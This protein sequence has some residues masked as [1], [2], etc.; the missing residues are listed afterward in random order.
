MRR[1]LRFREG[2]P[3][4]MTQLLRTQFALD[5]SLYFST[6]EVEPDDRDAATL[7][8]PVRITATKS[9]H[10]FTLGA[11]YG[12]DTSVRGTIG[13]TNTRVN[14]RGHRLRFELKASTVTQRIDARY[15]IPIGDPALEQF[16][17][18]LT[19]R[20]TIRATSIPPRPRS[21]PR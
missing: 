16:S 11:G 7:T 18:D 9:T 15:D 21:G 10:Q 5:D 17:V 1:F 14:D 2:D 19:S 3:Y 20:S 13:W 8:V 6:V 4:S 12:T